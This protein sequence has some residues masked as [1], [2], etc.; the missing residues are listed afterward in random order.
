MSLGD[1]VGVGV[2]AKTK[3]LVTYLAA[4]GIPL[5]QLAGHFHDTYGQAGANVWAAYEC[6]L[7]VFDS[8]V[9]GLGGCP[10]APGAEGNVATED[11]VY[12]FEQAGVHT[13][14]DLSS[15][16][17]TGL[18][19]SAQ[20]TRINKSRAGT[21]LA[22]RNKW[23]DVVD[24]SPAEQVTA[25]V[26]HLRWQ[27]VKEFDA[28]DDI[29]VEQFGAS[30]KITLNRP[31]NG[32]ALTA[33]M[34]DQLTMIFEGLAIKHPAVARVALTAKGK[35]FCTGMDLSRDGT[36]VSKGESSTDAQYQRLTR[37]MDAIGNAPQVTIACIQGP[38]FGGGVGLAF[39]CDI[40]LAA[41]EVTMRLSEVSL[42][43]C[44]ATISKYIIREWGPAFAREAML[45]GRT[46]I[47][48]ELAQLGAVAGI[49]DSTEE[50]SHKLDQFLVKLQNSAPLASKM[51]KELVLLG[52]SEAGQ[53]AQ[54]GGVKRLFEEMMSTK[55]EAAYGLA[56]LQRGQ[57]HIDWDAV[58][59]KD[60]KIGSQFSKARL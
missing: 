18:W 35:Y 59:A 2:P 39:A 49:A 30:L 47:A 53:D 5:S 25:T 55:S 50:L 8:S 51:C 57:K 19:I 36:P 22:I 15:L 60:Y 17:Q 4:E 23:K 26:G 11:L 37:L 46:V 29:I 14:V 27:K 44:P 10:Y 24:A 45:T 12:M 52:W 1:T 41:K 21:A 32:N 48:T 3:S 38:A 7:R 20:L 28:L 56:C 6:G 31:R 40:R 33:R 42:G 43:L 13:G 54:A 16:V 34:I 58:V 9:S